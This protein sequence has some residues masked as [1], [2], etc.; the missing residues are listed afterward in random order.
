MTGMMLRK[1]F[2]GQV[3]AL[4][5]LLPGVA[6]P[7]HIFIDEPIQPVP[8]EHGQDLSRVAL[9]KRLFNDTRLSADDSISCATCHQLAAGGDDGRVRS[10]GVGGTQ[11]AINSPTVFNAGF[12]LAQFWDGRVHS[13]EE[14][15]DGPVHHPVE[16]ASEWPDVVAKLKADSGYRKAFDEIYADPDGHAIAIRSFIE[17]LAGAHPELAP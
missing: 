16:M 14:Q 3:V 12:N 1:S 2:H 10:L 4:A 6:M 13:L 15:V 11:G 8:A 5:L 17:S 9:G 7:G